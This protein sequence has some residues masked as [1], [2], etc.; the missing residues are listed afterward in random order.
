MS[1]LEVKKETA[2]AQQGASAAWGT[3]GLDKADILLPKVLL[4]QA[5][6]VAVSEGKCKPGD[7][8]RSTN[9][10]VLA[11]AE[12]DKLPVVV[13]S[14]F[15]SW[16]ISEKGRSQYE[17][18]KRVPMLATDAGL[19]LEWTDKSSDGRSTTEWRRDREINFYVLLA[20]DVAREAA[21]LKKLSESGDLPDPDDALLPC[22][23]SFTRSS[24]Q[25]GKILSTHLAKAAH[26]NKP[27]ASWVFALS[28]KK[29]QNDQGNVYF[30]M[31]IGAKTERVSTATELEAARKWHGILTSGAVEVKVDEG[32]DEVAPVGAPPVDTFAKDVANTF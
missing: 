27:P 17:F 8:Y 13:I 14:S 10:E 26:F 15:K 30:V 1:N 5:M 25:A 16:R 2:L 31:E 24:Y 6:S 29:T 32:D 11:K 28:T 12:A 20:A 22:V 19:P 23:I 4:A 3:E 7:L 21:A 9:S 18:R